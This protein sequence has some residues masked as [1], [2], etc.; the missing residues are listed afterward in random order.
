MNPFLIPRRPWTRQCMLPL[1]ARP[2]LG[3]AAGNWQ[4]LQ[5]AAGGLPVPGPATLGN[6]PRLSGDAACCRVTPRLDRPKPLVFSAMWVWALLPILLVLW[7]T[8]GF[9]L[10]YAMAVANGSV[11]VTV[12]FPYIS[13]CGSDPPQSCIFGQVMNVG[14]FLVVWISYLRFQ[15]VRD[16]GCPCALNTAGLVLGLLCA[17]GA[18][19]VAN[20]QQN[21]QLETHLFGVFLAFVVGIVYF[22]VQA[23]LTQQVKP[24]HGGGWLGPARFCLCATG[25]AL[26]VAMC[27]LHG[28]GLKSEAAIC[29]WALTQS[30]FLL[31]GLFAEDFRHI[32]SCC[33]RLQG[34][35]PS[36]ALEL[37]AASTQTLAL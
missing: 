15:Q 27:A 32:E 17:L 6:Q 1:G 25:T 29:E 8:V 20:F 2:G 33:V 37:G 13:T 30:L 3:T 16:W 26:L 12:V 14:S 28:L 9:W 24:R 31:F 19:V 21:N 10:V 7:G 18:S 5:E 36:P 22:W 4:R 34:R 23:A 11:N 35:A